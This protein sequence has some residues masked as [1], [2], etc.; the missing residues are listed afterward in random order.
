V[1]AAAV[2]LVLAIGGLNVSAAVADDPPVPPTPPTV[3]ATYNGAELANCLNQPVCPETVVLGES[4]TFTL[5]ATSADVVRFDYNLNS[6]YGSVDGSSAT[7]TLTPTS[8]ALQTLQVRGVSSIGQ[9]GG[10]TY[11]RFNVGPRPAPIGSWALDDGSGTTAADGPGLTH[12]LTLTGGAAFDGK[13][14]VNGSAAFDGVDDFAQASESVVDTSK[15]FS[16][17]A[18]ARPTS[19]TKNG[20]VAAVTGTNSS[21]FGLY[22]DAASKRWVFARTSADVTNPTL[23][24]ASSKEAPI[25]TAWTHL[26]GTYDA[27][28]GN[29]ELFV[30]GQLQQTATSPTTPAWNAAGPLTVGRGKFAGAF[31]GYFA[32]SLDQIAI[33]QRVLAADEIPELVDPRLR[34]GVVSSGVAAYWP[35]DDATRVGNTWRTAEAVRGADLTVAGFTGSQAGAFVDD[36]Q[37]G[38]VLEMTGHT[39]ESLTL[40]HAAID[41]SASFT[42]AARVKIGDPSKSMVVARQGTSGKDTWRI[43]YRP[44]DATSSQWIFARGDATSTTETTA[45]VTVDR[46]SVTSWHLI[47]ATYNVA[48]FGTVDPRLDISVDLRGSAHQS[49]PAAPTRGGTTAIGTSRTTT[50][51]FSGRID[52]LRLYAGAAAQPT[53]APTYLDPT[54]CG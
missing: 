2:G 43:E 5:T 16:I 47:S 50:K 41:G 48:S 6:T 11:F 46:E 23:Y 29:L 12:P 3:T 52:D 53:L 30:N 14:R 54:N 27:T 10:L 19:S 38:R 51:P 42:V 17:S 40:D 37:Y 9:P 39:R 20:V 28:T 25:N 26:I 8:E 36:P 18:W 7:I 35:L 31:T 21:A 32:G 45:T 24:R 15:S 33:W 44:V 49:F 34:S 13:G 22:Y 1:T 4:V